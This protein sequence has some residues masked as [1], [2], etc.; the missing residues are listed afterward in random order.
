MTTISHTTPKKLATRARIMSCAW[1]LFLSKGYAGTST[2]DIAKKADIANGTLFSHFENKEQLLNEL[3]QAHFDDVI[4]QAQ[5][6]DTF[7]LPKLKLRHYAQHLYA[8]FLSYQEFTQTLLQGL[9]CQ[10]VF[11][12]SSIEKLK[13]QLFVDCDRYDEVRAAAMMDCFF[14]TLIEGLNTQGITKTAMV[15]RLSAKLALL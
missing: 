3:M 6:D 5:Q 10:G 13:Q 7:E 2:R 8:F 11:F 14:M 9:V 12:N 4:A 15:S 1:E